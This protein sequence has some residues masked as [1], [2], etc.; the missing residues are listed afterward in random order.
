MWALILTDFPQGK[1]M[2]KYFYAMSPILVHTLSNSCIKQHGRAVQYLTMYGQLDPKLRINL[3]AK[4]PYTGLH[5]RIEEDRNYLYSNR[6]EPLENI[7]TP[8]TRGLFQD[9]E[10][11][12]T[13][14]S[15]SSFVRVSLLPDPHCLVNFYCTESSAL[16]T[17]QFITKEWFQKIPSGKKTV[18]LIC[19]GFGRNKQL[20]IQFRIR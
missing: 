20:S 11:S 10:V 2:I 12:I 17:R 3:G 16:V 13:R 19:R 18:S 1:S 6:K 14:V 15:I 7:T 5:I 9:C 4:Y 8:V